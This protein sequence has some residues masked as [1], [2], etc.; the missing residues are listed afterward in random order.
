MM[1]PALDLFDEV[2]MTLESRNEARTWFI[3]EAAVMR[4]RSGLGRSYDALR[5]ACRFAA[6][7][8]ENPGP[9]DSRV[10]IYSLLQ[11]ALETWETGVRP[12]VV[13]FKSL[14]LLAR[15]EGY[16]VAQE[17]RSRL[18]PDA[19]TLVASI[20]GEPVAGQSIDAAEVADMTHDLENYLRHHTEIRIGA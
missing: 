19:R 16:P 18:S 2:Q 20:L 12:D 4:R 15:N 9:E 13:Y 14:Y 11:R 6:I 7:I 10:P 1:T 8:R 17:W 3:K 5:H